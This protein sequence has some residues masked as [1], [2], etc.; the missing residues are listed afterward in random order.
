MVF[1]LDMEERFEVVVGDGFLRNGGV[2]ECHAIGAVAEDFHEG[3]DAHACVEELGG[4]GVAEPVGGNF[5]I[6]GEAA[7][8]GTE[9]FCE[10]VVGGDASGFVFEEEAFVLPKSGLLQTMDDAYGGI[11]EGDESFGVELSEGDFEEVVIVGI[12][13]DAV[14]RQRAELADANTGFTHEEKSAATGGVGIFEA[15]SQ[16]EVDIGGQGFGQILR[17]PGDVVGADEGGGMVGQEPFFAEPEQIDSE[18]DGS[19]GATGSAF[20]VSGGFCKPG[21]DMVA[22]DFPKR[23][24]SDVQPSIKSVE[25]RG[26]SG[27]GVFFAGNG[28]LAKESLCFVGQGGAGFSPR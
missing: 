3:E 1:I 22:P 13:D 19:G 15:R 17:E 26:V 28:E 11:I 20:A 5:R 21:G 14:L 9:S 8:R 6:E 2:A 25:G 16:S 12:G 27:D 10:G 4:K 7:G 23:D 18:V 24:S